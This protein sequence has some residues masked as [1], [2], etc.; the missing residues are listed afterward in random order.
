MKRQPLTTTLPLCS[1]CKHKHQDSLTFRRSFP[2]C[3]AFPNG[4]PEAIR[5]NRIDHRKALAGD[6][7]VRFELAFD[8]EA[9][10]KLLDSFD[11]LFEEL[12]AKMK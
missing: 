10:R 6:N 9:S 8:S 5:K 12:K 4:I 7:G 2:T 1:I 11:S 3:D